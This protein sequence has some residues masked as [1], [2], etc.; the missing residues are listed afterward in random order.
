MPSQTLLVKNLPEGISKGGIENFFN[1][2]TLDVGPAVENVGHIYKA[3]NQN[4]RRAV[5]TFLSSNVAAQALIRCKNVE[6]SAEA[7]APGDTSGRSRIELDSTF[8]EL[9]VLY[10]PENPNSTN[11]E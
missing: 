8:H 5:V 1:N 7:V 9:T 6:I 2:R 10:E 3:A 11:I 4:T